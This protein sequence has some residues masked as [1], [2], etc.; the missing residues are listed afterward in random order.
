M[1]EQ[2]QLMIEAM[3]VECPAAHD[4]EGCPAC[5]VLY[6]FCSGIVEIPWANIQTLISRASKNNA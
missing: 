5:C 6:G 1:V 4:V 3:I 2:T